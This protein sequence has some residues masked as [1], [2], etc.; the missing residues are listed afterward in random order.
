MQ[1]LSEVSKQFKQKASE[2]LKNSKRATITTHQQYTI[3]LS[4]Y[5]TKIIRSFLRAQEDS[6]DWE[7][8]TIPLKV[9]YHVDTLSS[10][11]AN[12]PTNTSDKNTSDNIS[13]QRRRSNSTQKQNVNRLIDQVE[14]RMK[15]ILKMSQEKTDHLPPIQKDKEYFPFKI[16]FPTLSN[17]GSSVLNEL[18]NV[19]KWGLKN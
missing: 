2:E 6:T 11:T 14:K 4:F 5:S 12:T 7:K 13:K 10:A 15:Y 9:V 19:F 18:Y 17:T 1:S 3:E 16:T 8:W